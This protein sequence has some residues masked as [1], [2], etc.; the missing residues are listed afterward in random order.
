M[1][2][3]VF[4]R[5]VLFLPA[6]ATAVAWLVIWVDKTTEA[7]SSHGQ[8]LVGVAL[9][10][11]YGGLWAAI[12]YLVVATFICV[13][14]RDERRG[15]TKYSYILLRAPV[16]VIAV[17]VF[18][19]I[20]VGIVRRDFGLSGIA[21]FYAVWGLI[22]GYGYVMVIVALHRVAEKAGWITADPNAHS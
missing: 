7:F 10:V 1:T 8:T 18:L 19:M 3:R 22:L 5:Q 15:G 16:A 21:L 20:M 11:G 17:G 6:I 12:P 14:L 4:Y 2:E 9:I 13:W